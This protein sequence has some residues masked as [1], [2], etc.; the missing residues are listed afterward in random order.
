MKPSLVIVGLGNPGAGYESARHNAGFRAVDTLSRAYGTGKWTDRQKFL[1][2]SQE[3]RIVTVPVLLVKP[4][5]F[6][7]RSGEA[8]RKVVDFFKLNPA[9]QLLVLTDDID[10]P[11]GD[12]RLRRSGG[13]G[14]HNGMRSIVE[15]LG[16]SFPRLRIGLGTPPD[17]SDLATWVLST[18]AKEEQSLLERSWDSIPDIVEEFVLGSGS[19][20]EH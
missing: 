17:G 15:A 9:E 2:R 19:A 6:M 16:E 12:I 14:T 20:I 11:I 3:A 1:S 8:V 7:N 4:Q 10:L 13:P 18:P 5:T